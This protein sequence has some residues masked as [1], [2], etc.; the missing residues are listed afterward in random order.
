MQYLKKPH[1]YYAEMMRDKK[2]KELNIK[3]ISEDEFYNLLKTN[4]SK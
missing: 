3:I 1:I 2:A 4:E